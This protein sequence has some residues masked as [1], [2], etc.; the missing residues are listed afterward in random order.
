MA[1]KSKNDAVQKVQSEF[2]KEQIVQS[3]RYANR[4]DL[5][6][7]LLDDGKKYTFETVDNEIEKFLKGKVK[8]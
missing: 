1:A 7:A 5:V 8:N 3:D 2:T 4:K 6:E